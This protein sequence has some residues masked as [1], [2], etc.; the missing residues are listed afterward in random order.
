[1]NAIE[2]NPPANIMFSCGR[3]WLTIGSFALAM[4]T[5]VARDVD[6]NGKHYTPENMKE[7]ARLINEKIEWKKG[8]Q[9]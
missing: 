6:V 1:M 9:E 2:G 7:F 5:D 4:E 3:C 8:V